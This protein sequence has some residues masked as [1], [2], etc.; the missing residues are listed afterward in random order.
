[1]KNNTISQGHSRAGFRELL[2]RVKL[3]VEYASFGVRDRE[4]VN[5]LCNIIAEIYLLPGTAPVQIGGNK[6]TA[7]TVSVFYSALT[8]DHLQYVIEEFRKIEYYIVH[9]KSYLRTMLYNAVFEYV[10]AAVNDAA[11]NTG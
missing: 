11:Q 5:E 9:K 10:S 6:L 1:M 4:Q 3:Q 2:E 7:E 8:G